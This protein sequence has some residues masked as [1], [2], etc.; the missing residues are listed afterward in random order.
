MVMGVVLA[1]W[2]LVLVSGEAT[3]CIVLAPDPEPHDL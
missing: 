1:V 2:A 3:D